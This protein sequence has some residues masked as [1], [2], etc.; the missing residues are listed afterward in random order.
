MKIIPRSFLRGLCAAASLFYIVTLRAADQNVTINL[1]FPAQ[2]MAY[3][4]LTLSPAPLSVTPTPPEG[5]TS[6]SVR[7][8][9]EPVTY[10]LT[11]PPNT[12]VGIAVNQ[13]TGTEQNT[14]I[15]LETKDEEGRQVS[16]RA[17]ATIATDNQEW[18]V[19]VIPVEASKNG[20][21]PANWIADP[22]KAPAPQPEKGAF[23]L[24]KPADAAMVT[25]TRR[26]ELSWEPSPGAV[27]Y[28]VYINISRTDYDWAAPG[29]LLDRYTKVGTMDPTLVINNSQPNVAPSFTPH[30]DLPDRWTY[31][32]YVVA[33]DAAGKTSQSDVGAFSVYLPVLTKVDDGVPVIDG[34][35]DLNKDGKIEPYED[36]HNS[37]AVRVADLMSRMTLH[38]KVM[39]LFFNTQQ[40]PL[41]GF[42]FGPF[43]LPDLP[44]Y[45]LATA[46]TRL[47]IP[48]IV[49]GDTIHGFKTVYP[50]Q[51]GLAATRDLQ[52]AWAVGDMQ[53]RESLA[54]GNRGSLSPLAEV[55]TKVLYPRI[56]EGCGEDADYAAAMVRAMVCGMQ[57]GPEVNPQSMM[58]TVKHWPSQGGGGES[59]VV[60]DGTTIWY[61]M[62][63][64]H[65]AIEAGASCIMP[66]YGG[67]WLLAAKGYGAGDDPGILSF[68]RNIMGYQGLICTDWLPSGAWVRACTNGSDVMGGATPSQMG[69]FEKQVPESRID[70]AVRR[71]LDLKFR[72][73]IF[74]DPY[75]RGVDGASEWH[76]AKNAAIARKAA[77]ESLT[78]LKNDGPL[79]VRLLPGSNIV[80]DGARADEPSCMVTWRSD[81]HEND[82]GSKT[83]Y[84]AIVERA[85]E[86]GI[87]VYG[88]RSRKGNKTMPGKIDLAIVVVGEN[89]FTHGTFWDKNSP[90]LPDDPIGPKHDERDA[91][92]YALIQ[93]YHDQHI[94][95]VVVCLLPRPYVLTNVNKLADALL[96]VYRPGD[97]GGTAIANLLWGDTAPQG[98]LPWQLPASMD[99]VGSDDAGHWQA[100]PDKWD[101]PFDLGATPAELAEIRGK[102]ADGKHVEPIYGKPLFQ[103]GAG[104][105][106]FGLKDA[107]PPI[108][109]KLRWPENTAFTDKVP[110]FAWNETSDPETGIQR[111]EL[112][113]DGKKVAECLQPSPG[114]QSKGTIV[115]PA[116]MEIQHG[117][118][119]N[120]EHS[121]QVKA[122]NWADGESAS[123]LCKFTINDTTPPEKFQTLAPANNAAADTNPVD[124]YWEHAKDTGSGLA[125]YELLLDGKV[126]AT[127][128]P[129]NSTDADFNLARGHD[130]FASS[131]NDGTPS[132]AVDGDPK[133][134]WGSRWTG[135]ANPDAEWFTVDLGAVYSIKEIK[136]TWESPGKEYLIQVSYDNEHWTTIYTRTGEPAKTEDLKDLNGTGRYVRMQGV[137]R[138]G[139]YGYSIW[140]MEVYGTGV[141]HASVPVPP[142]KHTWQVRAIDGAGNAA[143]NSNGE[144]TIAR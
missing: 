61:H 91:P 136:F 131:T 52:I 122:V 54:V 21:P 113:V 24:K 7:N 143:T 62:R 15:V 27:N 121:W 46:K 94:P 66:G 39:Q 49:L 101:L 123:P 81:F 130:A 128:E 107:T 73:G 25:N 30:N 56:Q 6:P 47:G 28:D 80:V 109:P 14:Q 10:K 38:E 23:R 110:P 57:G 60:Y 127:V 53:R 31:K 8:P 119:A 17:L 115:E 78:L 114:P 102:I 16:G 117:P 116:M 42:G 87:T 55:G 74:E 5:I 93:Q 139:G 12:R 88:P 89:Y 69:D 41:A 67:S 86:E 75:S 108:P 96:V 82:F 40:E 64:W 137:K 43:S 92:Q 129:S 58:I 105:Q 106:G 13:F 111:Y 48:N 76:T 99:Q 19:R 132:G 26:P 120:G 36:W 95:V 98:K 83:I 29:N 135:V 125:K 100:Q 18:N 138:A 44:K 84:Q 20:N 104:I 2:G 126:V 68:L 142:G 103:F 37:P 77:A 4:K 51:P 79:P 22:Y 70:D 97:E 50:T 144:Q 90:Y 1:T 33:T 63:P 32:W 34:C 85:A 134:R 118:L 133:S 140:E 112:Y 45:Q 65:A 141:E 59:G 72:L 11:F 35:R 9:T 71:V 3:A 124:F